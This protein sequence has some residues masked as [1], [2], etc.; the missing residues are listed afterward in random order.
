MAVKLHCVVVDAHQNVETRRGVE[1][2]GNECPV[3]AEF[4]H[5]DCAED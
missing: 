2:A 1:Q 4:N 3:F 5:V